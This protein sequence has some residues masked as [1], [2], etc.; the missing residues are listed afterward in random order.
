MTEYDLKFIEHINSLSSFD[1]LNLEDFDTPFNGKLSEEV[2]ELM[3]DKI[4]WNW[5]SFSQNLSEDFMRKFSNKI[6][7][8]Y[9]S[10]YQKLSRKFIEDFSNKLYLRYIPLCRLKINHEQN[11]QTFL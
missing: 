1:A 3:Q 7:F 2:L 10:R 8:Y 11:W 6:S 4:N 5:V 9:I